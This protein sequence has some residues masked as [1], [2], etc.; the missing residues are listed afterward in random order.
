MRRQSAAT[1]ALLTVKNNQTRCR[2]SLATA[3][4]KIAADETLRVGLN[5]PASS[6]GDD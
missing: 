3:L 6:K 4:Q 5:A 1:T 2:A